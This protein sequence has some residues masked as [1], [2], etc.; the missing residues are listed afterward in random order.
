MATKKCFREFKT[1]IGLFFVAS[2]VLTSATEINKSVKQAEV[3]IITITAPLEMPPTATVPWPKASVMPLTISPLPAPSAIAPL[4]P[5]TALPAVMPVMVARAAHPVGDDDDRTVTTVEQEQDTMAMSSSAAFTVTVNTKF[6]RDN[7]FNP[8]VVSQSLNSATI[9]RAAAMA[10]TM[11]PYTDLDSYPVYKGIVSYLLGE[12]NPKSKSTSTEPTAIRLKDTTTV[13][14]PVNITSSIFC[15]SHLDGTVWHSACKTTTVLIDSTGSTEAAAS[16]TPNWEEIPVHNDA[17]SAFMHGI[18][19]FQSTMW[20][21]FAGAA[22][23]LLT[24]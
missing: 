1:I 4:G 8:T 7:S 2:A 12:D 24:S 17:A 16:K 10:Q 19:R 14:G 11:T 5:V 22:M 9:T 13:T 6:R 3:Y 20:A 18:C 15:L 21:M 23:L